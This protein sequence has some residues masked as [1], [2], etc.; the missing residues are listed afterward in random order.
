MT[1]PCRQFG[2]T[3]IEMVMVIVITGIIAAAV[4][5]FMHAPIKGYFDVV[6]RA[7]MTDRADLALRRIGRDLRLALPNS[8]RVT[9]LGG[10]TALEFLLTRAGGRYRASLTAVGAGDMLDF[11]NGSDTSFDVLGPAVSV[12]S[13][14]HLVIYNLGISGADAYADPALASSGSM[15]RP[16]SGAG[17]SLNAITFSALPAALP[18]PFLFASPDSRFYIVQG[19]VSYYCDLVTGRLMRFSAYSINP[20]Q[21]VPPAGTGALMAEN[22]TACTMNYDADAIAKRTGLVTLTLTLTQGGESITLYQTA[23]VNNAP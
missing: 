13:G 10:N 18:A 8:V 15:R 20:T 11:N 19:P 7:E 5:V 12:A 1:K 14:D 22:V 4:A 16:I 9:T 2:F 3:L 23:H 6:R 21:A 17:G